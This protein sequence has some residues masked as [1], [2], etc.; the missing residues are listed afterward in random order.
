MCKAPGYPGNICN[1]CGKA[2]VTPEAYY[3]GWS[4]AF[5]DA[6]C[7]KCYLWARGEICN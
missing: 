5:F 7:N 3:L 2:G 4:R 6:L 1:I